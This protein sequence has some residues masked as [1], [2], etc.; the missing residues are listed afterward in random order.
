VIGKLVKNVQRDI[1]LKL[2][3]A[4]KAVTE[5]PSAQVIE[6]LTAVYARHGKFVL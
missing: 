3:H 6:R 5:D 2:V 4:F 1:E